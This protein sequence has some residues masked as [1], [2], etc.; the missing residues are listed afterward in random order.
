MPANG[1]GQKP[2]HA[3]KQLVNNCNLNHKLYNLLKDGVN[4]LARQQQN[5]RKDC[6]C[7]SHGLCSRE[8]AYRV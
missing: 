6:N 5:F 1:A 2:L 8:H 7:G 4:F 3:T